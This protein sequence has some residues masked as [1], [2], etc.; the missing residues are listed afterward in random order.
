[1]I[2]PYLIIESSR[3]HPRGGQRGPKGTPLPLLLRRTC[4]LNLL[5]PL[6]MNVSY[7]FEWAAVISASTESF[8]RTCCCWGALPLDFALRSSLSLT[9]DSVAVRII[10]GGEELTFNSPFD[11]LFS[12]LLSFHRC[13]CIGRQ[14]PCQ[15][16][17]WR[18]LL[19]S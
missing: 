8:Y 16:T 6:T 11:P 19:M 18:L 1:M 12:R 17:L 7:H 15:H 5:Y 2:Q 3:H 14:P 10:A 4:C 13:C 9:T